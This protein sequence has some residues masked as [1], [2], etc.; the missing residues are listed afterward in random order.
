MNSVQEKSGSMILIG[1]GIEAENIL[2]RLVNGVAS[3]PRNA[4]PLA[5]RG[6]PSGL[7][8]PRPEP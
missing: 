5:A 6:R 4:L 8:I 1:N 2:R 3:M 7:G